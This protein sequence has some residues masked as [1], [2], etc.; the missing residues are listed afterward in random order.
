MDSS[1]KTDC[2]S[3]RLT[4]STPADKMAQTITFVNSKQIEKFMKKQNAKRVWIENIKDYLNKKHFKGMT[5]LTT[6]TGVKAVWVD[7][8]GKLKNLPSSHLIHYTDEYNAFSHPG[9]PF[10]K[11]YGNVFV[12]VSKKVWDA[13][14]ADKKKTDEEI[15]AMDF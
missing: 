9:Q 4:T 13:L 12:E 8:E 2:A 7:E 1:S 5:G 10:Q 14:P 3:S 11:I 6:M 15:L